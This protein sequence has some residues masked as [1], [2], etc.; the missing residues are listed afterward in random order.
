MEYDSA[1][2]ILWG[3]VNYFCIPT[4]IVA[5]ALQVY[6]AMWCLSLTTGAGP[7]V[8][9][10]HRAIPKHC[11]PKPHGNHYYYYYCTYYS[12]IFP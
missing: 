3:C 10:M 9:T 7:V 2:S 6:I 5:I 1:L 4:D 8:A 11:M 12:K